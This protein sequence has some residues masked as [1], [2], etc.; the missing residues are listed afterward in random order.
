[1]VLTAA[2]AVRVSKCEASSTDTLLQGVSAG[3]VTF[4]QLLPPS[5]VTWMSPSS[6]PAQM[7]LALRGLGA[8]A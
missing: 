2:H 4:F 8:T 6:L 7:T 1:M 3:G 5:V